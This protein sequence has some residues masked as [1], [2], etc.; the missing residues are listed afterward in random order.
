MQRN[1]SGVISSE[2]AKVVVYW[3]AYSTICLQ[4]VAFEDRIM[5]VSK[6]GLAQWCLYQQKC[7]GKNFTHVY[8][9]IFKMIR[10]FLEKVAELASRN[11]PFLLM[12]EHQNIHKALDVS[13]FDAFC[14]SIVENY[15]QVAITHLNPRIL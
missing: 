14:C 15:F 12:I 10:Y 4:I 5:L 3:V 2:Y 6:H 7:K 11:K 8:S 9:Y 1:F 13:T